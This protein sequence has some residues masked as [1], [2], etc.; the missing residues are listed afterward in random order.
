[1][2]IKINNKENKVYIVLGAPH[3]ATSFISKLLHENGVDMGSGR[4]FD[5]DY[6]DDDI[7]RINQGILDTA[8]GDLWHPPSEEQ[9][10]ATEK[11]WH[12]RRI[13]EFFA[14]RREKRFWGFKDTR[15]GLTLKRLIPYLEGDVYLI[16]CFRRPDRTKR[17]WKEKK[18]PYPPE[19]VD[20]HNKAAIES[21]KKFCG[22]DN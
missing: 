18:Y 6:Q 5:D 16:A 10:M 3:S 12:I 15:T 4:N 9:I 1:M 19:V 11:W 8:G 13:K 7:R 2:G 14:K 17:S 20:Q 22:F 21:I